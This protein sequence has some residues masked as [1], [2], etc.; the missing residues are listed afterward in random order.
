MKNFKLLVVA[1]IVSVLTACELND[2][3][4]QG[5][6]LNGEGPL[7]TDSRVVDG[8]FSTILHQIPGNI[9]ITSGSFPSV[10]V[11]GQSNLLPFLETDV[12]DGILTV[13]FNE[14]IET[15]MAFNVFVTVTDLETVSLSGL[16]D[17]VFNNEL[18]TDRLQLFLAGLGNYSVRGTVD[19]VEINISGQGNVSG[20]DLISDRCDI[21]I[22]GLGDVE[23]T[24][25]EELFVMIN[26]QGNVFYKGTPEIDSE[27]NG[28]G[29]VNDA[30]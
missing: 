15:G 7:V 25:N 23:I 16:G 3:T 21:F 6:C 9:F 30:N 2:D 17:V 22:T 24:A 10:T 20:F 12:Q 11:E 29:T 14:C 8:N 19:T 28:S 5:A 4:G 26:G 13:W 18:V 27:I 1:A